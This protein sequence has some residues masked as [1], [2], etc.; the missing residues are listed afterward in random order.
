MRYDVGFEHACGALPTAE[1]KGPQ[2]GTWSEWL[3]ASNSVCS[4]HLSSTTSYRV[5]HWTRSAKPVLFTAIGSASTTV[6]L[7]YKCVCVFPR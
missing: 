2:A 5:I 3:P 1:A 7:L 4:L 6:F